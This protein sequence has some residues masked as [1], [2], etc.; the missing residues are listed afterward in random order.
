MAD[1]YQTSVRMSPDDLKLVAALAEKFSCSRNAVF[2]RS[3]RELAA[4]RLAEKNE[5]EDYQ[6]PAV[7][8]DGVGAK[9]EPG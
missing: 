8:A 9:M 6:G 7:E 1:A 2:E 5:R 3:V 4:R